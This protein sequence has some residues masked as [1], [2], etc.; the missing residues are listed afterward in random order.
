MKRIIDFLLNE[1]IFSNL[2]PYLLKLKMADMKRLIFTALLL[3][4]VT[5]AFGQYYYTPFVN[6]GQNPANLNNDAEQPDGYLQTY[7]TGYTNILGQSAS[8]AWTAQQSIPFNFNFSGAPV[9][10]YFVSSSGVVTFNATVGTA[11]SHTNATLPDGSIPD[12]S[13]VVWG[14]NLTGGNDAIVTKT[15]GTA[16]N[17][18][19]WIIWASASQSGLTGTNWT[20]WGIVLEESSND[21]HIVDMRSYS[22]AGGNTAITAGI[23]L[24]GATAWS[25]AGSPTLAST[26]VGTGG[27]QSDAGDNS[28]YTFSYGVPPDYDLSLDA[29]EIDGQNDYIKLNSGNDVGGMVTNLGAKTITDYE[30]WYSMD[31]AAAQKSVQSGFS[32]APFGTHN[33]THS[34]SY[35]PSAGGGT[36]QTL[37]VWI[38][39]INTNNPDEKNHNDTMSGDYFLNK[40]LASPKK[41][42]LEEFTTAP[43]GYCPDGFL[44]VEE[45][46]A[47]HPTVIT[48]SIHAGFQTDQ[49]TIPEHSAWAA[50]TGGAPTAMVDRRYYKGESDVGISRSI[51]EQKVI[52]EFNRAVPA[53]VEITGNYNGSSRDL[54]V[55]VK[56]EFGDYGFPGQYRLNMYIVEDSVVGS[57]TGY[58]QINYYSSQR[59]ANGVNDPT[60]P[61]YNEPDPIVGYVHPM[62]IREVP[63]GTWGEAGLIGNNPQPNESVS[64]NFNFTLNQTYRAQHAYL[65]AFVA[66]HDIDMTKRP[67]INSTSVKVT[68]LLNVGVDP[69][70]KAAAGVNIYPNPAGS[71]AYLDITLEKQSHV[72]VTI[73]N[74][75]GQRVENIVD[76]NY[77]RGLHTFGIHSSNLDAGVYF[78]RVNVNGQ[79][80]V[81]EFVVI[82]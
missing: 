48:S 76:N 73:T 10:N 15:F 65:V 59:G 17:Q 71:Y 37:K 30:V 81:K 61:F 19:H 13:V 49:M 9:T 16:P 36:F 24:D 47:N 7:E 3:F 21:I 29:I 14:V 38:G 44:V 34:A 45:I 39:N 25:V 68:D 28:Y 26:N 11:P 78:A 23:Q 43:C 58:D 79:I 27:S 46:R 20:Y 5:L 54:N 62:V 32:I 70:D 51:W 4:S 57:G 40:G 12:K 56:V 18:Q 80:I 31:G 1:L 67:I 55:D 42:L 66:M 63:T 22:S 50:M 35:N 77:T 72:S 75:F 64:K 33:F 41:V 8:P 6:A 2:E 60:H 82:K 53:H 69:A 74:M 52:E